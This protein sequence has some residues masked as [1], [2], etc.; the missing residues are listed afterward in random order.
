MCGLTCFVF[1]C[2]GNGSVDEDLLDI[3]DEAEDLSRALGTKPP[4]SSFSSRGGSSSVVGG[5]ASG[6]GGL[7]SKLNRVYQLTGFSDPVYVES[8]L[9]VVDFDIVLDMLLV[10]QSGA[11]LQN[12][13]VELH[14][15]GDLKVVDRPAPLTIAPGGSHRLRAT[16]KLSSTESGVIFGNVVYDNAS[17][18]QRSLVVLNNIHLDVED[19]ISPATCSD[20]AFRSMWAEFEWENKVAVNTDIA[21][22]G[23]YL[24]HVLRIT[25]MKCMTP[26]N[27]LGGTAAFLAANLYA[28]SMFGEDALLNLS[29]EKQKND[30]V[31]GYIRI[32]SKTQGIA[33]S[34]GDKIQSRQRSSSSKAQ[35]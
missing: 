5:G 30:K 16:I 20:V 3:E 31:A 15:S 11:I 33:L 23:A 4:S 9:A 34:L 13:Q 2:A 14:T 29:V 18:T 26:M 28:R 24:D 32:R 8:H 17:G 22:L 6:S 1:V 21:D 19:Y 10:N 12:L 27:T 25:N 35:L 7:V